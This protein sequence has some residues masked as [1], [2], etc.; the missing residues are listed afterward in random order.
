MFVVTGADFMNSGVSSCIQLGM[1]EHAARLKLQA[2]IATTRFM[3]D[4]VT[5]SA[6]WPLYNPLRRDGEASLA[7]D[8]CHA[9]CE[10]AG[11]KAPCPICID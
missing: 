2:A 8:A 6:Y 10:T 1:L 11:T 4:T 9:F 5:R 7:P 3:V